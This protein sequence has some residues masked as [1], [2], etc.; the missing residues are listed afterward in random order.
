MMETGKPTKLI[1]CSTI[2][3]YG[4]TQ[5]QAI[6]ET[7][8]RTQTDFSSAY[9]RTKYQ[10][11]Q[12]VNQAARNGLPIIS[13]MPSGILGSDDPHFGPVIKLFLSG[14]LK[15]WPGGDRITGIVHVDD[16]V[17]AM[18]LAVEKGQ[19]GEHYIISAGDLSTRDMFKLLSQET[20]IATP[21]EPP[22][23]LVRFLGQML[24]PVGKTLKW[25]PPLSRERIHYIYDRCVRVDASKARRELG[26]QPRSVETLLQQIV[27]ELQA[28]QQQAES[29]A[30]IQQR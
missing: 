22:R 20:G 18:L 9:D 5:G 24:D 16:L 27:Q 29:T 7:F 19:P 17:N 21:N 1:Y 8:Q 11:Q 4:D 12:I 26:W 3:I 25:N 14:W 28:E 30:T 6:D 13:L 10:A 15:F 23:S 2:G